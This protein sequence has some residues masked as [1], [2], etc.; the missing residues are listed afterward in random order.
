MEI[1]KTGPIEILLV[2][3]NPGDVG[4]IEEALSV[5]KVCNKLHIAHDGVEAMKFLLKQDEFA[6]APCPDL[7]L[8]DLNLPKKNGREVL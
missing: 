2:E 1:C 8:L 6:D 4:L 3:D 5:S 7:I